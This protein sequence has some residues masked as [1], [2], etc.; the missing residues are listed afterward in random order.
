MA[1]RA[2]EGADNKPDRETAAPR[3][4]P[5]GQGDKPIGRRT[6]LAILGLGAL[7][8]A[9]GERVQNGITSLLTPLRSSGLANIVPGRGRVRALHDHRR[10]PGRSARLPPDRRRDGRPSPQPDASPTS[11]RSRPP[12]LDHTFQCV[13]GWV[14]PDVHWVGVRLT[15]LARHAG[16][17][18]LKRP[19]SGS[20]RSMASTPRA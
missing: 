9:F 17:H 2:T 19:P 20:P 1:G 4:P 16:A 6:V 18:A 13:T 10:L 8:I 15:D 5:Q 7:G 3:R 12:G 14:V 11:R